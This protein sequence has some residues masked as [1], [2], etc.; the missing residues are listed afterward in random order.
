MAKRHTNIVEIRAFDERAAYNHD[1]PISG[2]IRTQLLHLHTA[3]TLR[4]PRRLQTGVNINNLLTEHQASDYIKAVTQALHEHGAV[5][6]MKRRA[7]K[8]RAT[9]RGRAGAPHTKVAHRRPTA[10]KRRG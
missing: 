7:V 1:R 10:S 9:S 3:E 8:K 2:L 5:K 4:L 6:D